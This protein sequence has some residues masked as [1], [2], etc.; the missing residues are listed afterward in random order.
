LDVEPSPILVPLAI[1]APLR[2]TAWEITVTDTAALIVLTLTAVVF[3]LDAIVLIRGRIVSVEDFISARHAMSADVI[4]LSSLGAWVMFSPSEAAARTGILALLGY[5]VGNRSA[6][7]V[8]ACHGSR[9]RQLLPEGH[10]MCFTVT[11]AP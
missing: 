1:D 8:F 9:M 6:I 11:G 5:A 2:R 7:A 10:A 4:A 3:A